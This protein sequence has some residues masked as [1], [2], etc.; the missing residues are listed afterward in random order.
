[1][2]KFIDEREEEIL[3][4]EVSD[5]PEEVEEQEET[6]EEPEQSEDDLPEKYRGKDI[7]DIVRMHQEAEKAMGATKL[8]SW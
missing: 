4:E 3:D 8:R 7:K 5:L 6:V 2:A 1:M